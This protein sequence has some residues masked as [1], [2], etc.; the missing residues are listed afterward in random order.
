MKVI[1][2]ILVTFFAFL[3]IPV[4]YVVFVKFANTVDF[5]KT[6]IILVVII[7]FLIAIFTAG[8]NEKKE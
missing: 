8:Y 7:A 4:H 6:P 5:T 3:L 1:A 2:I